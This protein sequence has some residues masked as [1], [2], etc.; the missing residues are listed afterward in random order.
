MTKYTASG[1]ELELKAK[2]NAFK[3]RAT[4]AKEAYTTARQN[5][6][7]NDRLSDTAKTS[8]LA[9]LAEQA[10]VTLAGIKSEQEAYVRGIRA[11]IERELRGNQPTDAN[12][13]LLRRDAADRARKIADEAAAI[14]VLGDAA[15]SGDDS[16]AH[17]VGYIARQSGWVDALDAYRTA[18]PDAADAATA[19][20]F[21]EGLDSD[22]GYNLANGITYADPAA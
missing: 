14:A 4:A 11:N 21:V 6:Q 22:P 17:A 10:S 1:V 3:T 18:Q 9:K 7:R 2:L 8:D 20:A 12:S 16:L 19:L 15:R 13:V 5:I